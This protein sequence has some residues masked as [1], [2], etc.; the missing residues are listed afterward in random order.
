MPDDNTPSYWEIRRLYSYVVPPILAIW[1]VYSAIKMEL[2]VG[3]FQVKGPMA[4]LAG[5]G[6]VVLGAGVLALLVFRDKLF[7]RGRYD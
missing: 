2:N 3:E 4:I 6:L 1:G 7:K 5:I